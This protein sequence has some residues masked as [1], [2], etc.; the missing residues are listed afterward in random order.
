MD[1][2]VNGDPLASGKRRINK[3]ITDFRNKYG[4]EY[5]SVWK[6]NYEK[7]EERHDLLVKYNGEIIGQVT[8]TAETLERIGDE[9]LS[10]HFEDIKSEIRKIFYKH[11]KVIQNQ[12]PAF[13][14]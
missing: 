8:L 1:N 5:K 3:I 2:M 10:A 9:K 11:H 14:G 7:Q 4:T 12:G 13:S 6:D